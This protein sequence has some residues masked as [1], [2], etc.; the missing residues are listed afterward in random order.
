MEAFIN[1]LYFTSVAVLEV[2]SCAC[3]CY[4]TVLWLFFAT[5]AT[6]TARRRQTTISLTFSDFHDQCQIPRLFQVFQVVGH[7]E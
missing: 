2:P 6:A 5:I 3:Q 7:P 1:K 4:L